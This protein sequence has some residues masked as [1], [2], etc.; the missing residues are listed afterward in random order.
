M[1]EQES[2]RRKERRAVDGVDGRLGLDLILQLYSVLKECSNFSSRIAD[3][4]TGL[5][6]V[7]GVGRFLGRVVGAAVS[8]VIEDPGW[9]FGWWDTFSGR[10]GVVGSGRVEDARKSGLI[11]RIVGRFFPMAGQVGEAKKAET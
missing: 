10:P 8:G 11:S 9:F 7:E 2:R 4:G 3:G 1:V 6:R 5:P